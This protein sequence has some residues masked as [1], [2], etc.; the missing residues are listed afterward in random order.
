MSLGKGVVYGTSMRQKL[1]TKSLTEAELVGVS[2]VLPQALWTRYFME[3]QGHGIE[4]N[5]LYQDNE[6]ALKL[7]NNGCR[8]S[9][10]WM[11]HINIRFFFIT[12]RIQN[13]EFR[14]AFCPTGDMVADYFTKPLQ[15]TL[16]RRLRDIIMNVPQSAGP[17]SIQ[18]AGPQE[19]VGTDGQTDEM[20]GDDDGFTLVPVTKK[21]KKKHQSQEKEI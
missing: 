14:V 17:A 19:C 12:D 9:G 5:V 10:K 8:L 11:C 16:F 7:E 21:K 18:P 1:N 13:K 15:G 4:D 3:A 2:D 20:D 6:S